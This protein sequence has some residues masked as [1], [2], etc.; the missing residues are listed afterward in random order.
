MG[1]V[2]ASFRTGTEHVAFELGVSRRQ[3]Q[4]EMLALPSARFLKLQPLGDDA[5][6]RHMLVADG[7]LWG[8]HRR[9]KI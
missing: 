4:T 7:T 5:W 3:A 1:G 2:L 9:L 6:S 8:Q